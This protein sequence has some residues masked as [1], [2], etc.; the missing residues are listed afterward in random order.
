MTLIVTK[1]DGLK[2]GCRNGLDIITIENGKELP[3]RIIEKEYGE[4][5]PRFISSLLVSKFVKVHTHKEAAPKS[6]KDIVTPPAAA[7]V[8]NQPEGNPVQ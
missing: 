1:K 8:E 2:I 3:E 5:A 6:G 4:N 7:A